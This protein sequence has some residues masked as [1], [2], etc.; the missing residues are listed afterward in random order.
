MKA[1][2]LPRFSSTCILQFLAVTIASSAVASTAFADETDTNMDEVVVEAFRLPTPLRDTGASIWIVDEALIKS[3]GYIH[4]TDALASAPGVTVN[5][6]GPFGGQAT[7]RIRGASSDQTLVLVDGIMV[8]DTSTPGGGFNFGVFD[9]SDVERIEVLKGPQSTLWGSD[10]IG[11]VINIVSKTPEAGLNGDVSASGGSFGTQQYRASVEGGNETGDFRISYSDISTDGISKAD[12][13]DGNTEE[14]G[15]DAETIS[16]KGGI[17][18]PGDARLTVNYRQT[19]GDTE[20]DSFGLATGTQDGDEHSETLLTTAQVSLTFPLFD[21]RLQNTLKY[22]DMNIDR[23]SFS[24]GAPSF[25][26]EGER[27]VIQY[28]GTYTFDSDHYLSAG[29]EDEESDN[30]VESFSSIGLYALYQFSPI[31]DA[32]VS[33]GIRQDDHDE[34]GSETVGRL[35]AAWAVTDSIDLR[36]SWGEGFK[37]PTIFQTTFFCCGAT[38]PNSDLKPESSE[39]F[40]VGLDWAFPNGRGGMSVTA[41]R[42]DTENQINFSFAVGGFENIDE[43]ASKGIELAI[44]YQLTET[45]SA[46]TNVTYLNSEDGNGQDLILIPRWTADLAFKWQ[47]TASLNTTLAV[48]YNDEEDDIRGTVDSWTRIDLSAVYTLNEHIEL[49]GRIENAS[50]EN[51][52]QTF[53]YGTPERSGYVG[54]TYAF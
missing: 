30:G 41:F 12:A 42:Q 49:F 45:L 36:A 38:G 22:G 4:M 20:F 46:A 3:R 50:D 5:Q 29:L 6:N 21:D 40:D 48:V 28:Q 16:F 44:D 23:D 19:D 39:A 31:E 26:S 9:V 53:G 52:Q 54:V 32:T 25:S 13:D 24:N 8:N 27:H 33:M 37:A 47:A 35:S 2:C 7:A 14:D 1:I 51:Y 18:L 10:A 15:Y 17:N 43:V 11:G 34:Y